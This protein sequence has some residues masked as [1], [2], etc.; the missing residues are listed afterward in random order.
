MYN[1]LEFYSGFC[2][3]VS[4]ALPHPPV[5]LFASVHALYRKCQKWVKDVLFEMPKETKLNQ[6]HKKGKLIVLVI[7]GVKPQCDQLYF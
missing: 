1:F 3:P 7:T 5:T 6:H 2:I 4:V